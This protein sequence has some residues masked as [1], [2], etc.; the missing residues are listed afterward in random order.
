M[1]SVYQGKGEVIKDF[2]D[3]GLGERVVLSLTKPYWNKGI[4]V[5][6]DN[7]FTSISRLE[8]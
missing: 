7:Y 2:V 4:K 8:K 6:F 1:L 3:Y 5:F